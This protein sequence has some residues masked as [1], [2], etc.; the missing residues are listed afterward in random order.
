MES[1]KVNA[2]YWWPDSPCQWLVQ[3]W[4]QIKEVL[5]ESGFLRFMKAHPFF[6]MW[7][8]ELM[9]HVAILSHWEESL[10]MND[11]NSKLTCQKLN[12]WFPVLSPSFSLL[13]FQLLRPKNWS[14][15]EFPSGLIARAQI[16]SLVRELIS[17]KGCYAWTKINKW[18]REHQ[19]MVNTKK[20]LKSSAV[21]EGTEVC[22]GELSGRNNKKK[23]IPCCFCAN[24]NIFCP[25]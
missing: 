10:M 12:S 14:Y 17:H 16:Q 22:P 1:W 2:N 15:W 21:I 19:L 23:F 24:G 25:G 18:K 13:S 6:W 8:R 9:I 20:Q 3:A 5:R 11:P 7:S 4:W